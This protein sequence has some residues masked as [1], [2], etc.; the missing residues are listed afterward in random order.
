[1]EFSWIYRSVTERF[2]IVRVVNLGKRRY[3]SAYNHQNDCLNVRSITFKLVRMWR[4][5]VSYF[6]YF[7]H[8]FE[9]CV[10]Y[11]YIVY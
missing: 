7:T 4:Y 1:M 10:M 3:Y 8:L 11:Y 5:E 9:I 2:L 6:L